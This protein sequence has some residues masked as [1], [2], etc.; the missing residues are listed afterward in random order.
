MYSAA[1]RLSITSR[2]SSPRGAQAADAAA[3]VLAIVGG[4]A[5]A[6]EAAAAVAAAISAAV[7]DVAAA[8][9]LAGSAAPVGRVS[10]PSLLTSPSTSTSPSRSRSRSV[11]AFESEPPTPDA[12]SPPAAPPAFVSDSTSPANVTMFG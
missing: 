4:T 9:A 10:T 2:R 6:L 3:M 1:A 8:A 11:S 5:M 12:T 7:G